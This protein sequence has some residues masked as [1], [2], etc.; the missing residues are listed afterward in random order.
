MRLATQSLS[1]RIGGQA[2]VGGVH[3]RADAAC[4][5]VLAFKSGGEIAWLTKRFG[6]RISAFP[7]T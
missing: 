2:H 4:G 3:G 6:C 7:A 1:E 5:I